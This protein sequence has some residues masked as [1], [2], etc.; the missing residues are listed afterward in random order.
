MTSATSSAWRVAST[1]WTRK[2]SAPAASAITFEAIEPPSL[3]VGF[4]A[5]DRTEKSLAGSA[6]HDRPPELAQLSQPAQQL[7]VVLERL[8]EA[9]PGIDPDPLLGDAAGHRRLDALGEEGADIVDHVV[10]DGVVLHRARA[11]LHVHQDH[12]AVALGAKRGHLRDR[13]ERR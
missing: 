12:A 2:T 5:G 1:S 13:R 8:A 7:E 6:D 3:L 10:V 4:A 11:S 9:D